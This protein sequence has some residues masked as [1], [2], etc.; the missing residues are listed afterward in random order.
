MRTSGGGGGG[1][2][3]R[4]GCVW[5]QGSGLR[6]GSAGNNNALQEDYAI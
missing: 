1:E 4:G 6:E 3:E 5:G 2:G